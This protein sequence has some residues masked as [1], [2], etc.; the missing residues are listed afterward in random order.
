MKNIYFGVYC[1]GYSV[2]GYDYPFEFEID[3]EELK[4]M[5]ITEQEDYIFEQIY[6]YVKENIE[7]SID[8]ND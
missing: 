7:I 2:G 4:D 5:T 6:Q 8:F 3:E 1:L